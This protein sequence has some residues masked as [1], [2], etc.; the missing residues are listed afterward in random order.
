MSSWW[1]RQVSTEQV[2]SRG[3]GPEV[4]LGL[5][6][7]L[8]RLSRWAGTAITTGS[9]LCFH[10]PGL[11]SPL[12]TCQLPGGCGPPPLPPVGLCFISPKPMLGVCMCVCV[13]VSLVS[14]PLPVIQASPPAMLSHDLIRKREEAGSHHHW[15]LPG[16]CHLIPACLDPVS[17]GEMSWETRQP[18]A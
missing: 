9:I 10:S 7:L 13:C 2:G 14:G 16:S 3:Q 8:Y 1:Q 5:A 18:P 17:G 15:A 12:A 6:R 4:L 11:S